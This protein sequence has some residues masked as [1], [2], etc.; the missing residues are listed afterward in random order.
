MII[1]AAIGT[2]AHAD[3]ISRL[4]HLIVYFPQGRCH[5]VRQGPGD[6][7]HVALPRTRSKNNTEAI[8]I[9]STNCHVHH[10]HG[11]AGQAKCHRPEAAS[12]NVVDYFVQTGG[13]DFQLILRLQTHGAAGRAEGF[14]G[15]DRRERRSTGGARIIAG[16]TQWRDGT[17]ILYKG[18][19]AR[20]NELGMWEQFNQLAG[21]SSPH[22]NEK[23]AIQT[24]R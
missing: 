7:H 19:I 14:A 2:A 22:G 18:M 9:V 21:Y 16:R 11:T 23:N 5:L 24:L 1:T 4:R 17:N 6:D 13:D 8:L 3:D 15:G 12:P 20:G 10:L